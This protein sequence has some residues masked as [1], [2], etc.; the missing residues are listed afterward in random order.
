MGRNASVNLQRKTSYKGN[1][2]WGWTGLFPAGVSY[3][4]LVA[5][6]NFLQISL[7]LFLWI[8]HCYSVNSYRIRNPTLFLQY[9]YESK[10]ALFS[11]FNTLTENTLS[12]ECTKNLQYNLHF[13]FMEDVSI[14]HIRTRY[15]ELFML[16][17]NYHV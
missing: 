4:N 7:V 14:L 3:R 16:I 1:K 6:E 12:L 5:K 10:E 9:S 13:W 2:K 17:L 11:S 15:K 8:K